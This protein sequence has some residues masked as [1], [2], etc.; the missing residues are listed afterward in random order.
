MKKLTS[1][2]DLKARLPNELVFIFGAMD[3]E[4][5]EAT[6][7]HLLTQSD[8]LV[9]HMTGLTYDVLATDEGVDC[10]DE[11]HLVSA[12][13][14]LDRRVLTIDM[15]RMPGIAIS[16]AKIARSGDSI[17]AGFLPKEDE[18]ERFGSGFDF[19][20]TATKACYVRTGEI[21]S[22]ARDPERE[23]PFDYTVI[24]PM[25]GGS[26][27]SHVNAYGY[28][29]FGEQLVV[30]VTEGSDYTP[31]SERYIANK[32]ELITAPG[33][34]PIFVSAYAKEGMSTKLVEGAVS[35][36]AYTILEREKGALG[37]VVDLEEGDKA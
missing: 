32:G 13:D 14:V 23:E 3:P 16:A 8:T 19:L 27:L 33:E 24:V 15:G 2:S 11:S 26:A 10:V 20:K 21:V 22:V 31:V 25:D 35:L 9:R 12:F 36:P 5:G 18:Q 1:I 6:K 34:A 37:I 17:F 28:T 7:T 4:T 29:R 30:A